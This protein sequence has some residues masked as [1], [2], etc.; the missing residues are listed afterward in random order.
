LHWILNR[1]AITLL[2]FVLAVVGWNVVVALDSAGIVEGLV[3][4]ANGAP[5]PDAKVVLRSN[6]L[7]DRAAKPIQAT[8]DAGGRFKLQ[9]V[10]Y[11]D[12]KITAESASLKTSTPVSYHLYWRAQNFVLPKPVLVKGSS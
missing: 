7:N 9:G 11:F 10:T 12:F 1:Y 5:V 2:A 3:V 8:T 6:E 4:D